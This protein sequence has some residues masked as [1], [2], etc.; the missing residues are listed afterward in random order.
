LD[1]L[2]LAPI[3]PNQLSPLMTLEDAVAIPRLFHSKYHKQFEKMMI[4][5]ECERNFKVWLRV[6]EEF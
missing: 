6:D 5:V 1:S 4:E 2:D 3:A